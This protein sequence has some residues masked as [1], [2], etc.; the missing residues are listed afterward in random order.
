MASSMLLH[1]I[2]FAI[3]FYW[4]A[5]LPFQIILA[6]LEAVRSSDPSQ[7]PVSV[8]LL[9]EFRHSGHAGGGLIPQHRAA[10]QAEPAGPRGLLLGLRQQRL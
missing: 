7:G 1:P 4:F 3:G 5:Q 9:L 2:T 10:H 8:W 6:G